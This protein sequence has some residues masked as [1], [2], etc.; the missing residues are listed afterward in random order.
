MTATYLLIKLPTHTYM[1]YFFR[2]VSHIFSKQINFSMIAQ[3]N[4]FKKIKFGFQD[5]NEWFMSHSLKQIEV[6]QISW[7]IFSRVFFI[8]INNIINNC[9]RTIDYRILFFRPF[10]RNAM[11]ISKGL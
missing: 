11:Q 3:K 9:S 10:V 5:S 7:I 1:E 8:I 4:L 6:S 2:K